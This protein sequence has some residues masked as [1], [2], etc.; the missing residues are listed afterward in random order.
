MPKKLFKNSAFHALLFCLFLTLFNWPIL[1]IPEQR[2]DK[3][4]FIFLFYTW[5]LLILLLLLIGISVRGDSS[6]ETKD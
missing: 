6:E 2:Q 1:S 5:G 3:T 4:L